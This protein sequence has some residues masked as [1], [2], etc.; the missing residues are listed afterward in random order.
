MLL[1]SNE[2]TGR[3]ELSSLDQMT[4]QLMNLKNE[5]IAY[6]ISLLVIRRNTFEMRILNLGWK[7]LDQNSCSL[8][9]SKLQ[10]FL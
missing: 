7:N 6:L 1:V 4:V 9:G 3:F 8:G 5:V 10:I 2:V